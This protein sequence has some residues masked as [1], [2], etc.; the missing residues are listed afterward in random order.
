MSDEP[1]CWWRY[2]NNGSRYKTCNYNQKEPSGKPPPKPIPRITP[3]E[4][5][6]KIGK[7][8]SKM[9]KAQQNEYH[10]LDM[11]ERRAEERELYKKNTEEVKKIKKEYYD[12]QRKEK[13]KYRDERLKRKK[14]FSGDRLSEY[15][16]MLKYKYDNENKLPKKSEIKERVG[17][18]KY[19]KL[20]KK[21]ED[22]VFK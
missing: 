5:V 3:D 14:E 13:Q 12:E 2:N 17:E 8:Y 1:K 7:E 22:A 6:S 9:S 4:F 16:K 20:M 19:N 15:L 10:R 18:E 11:A 21:Y